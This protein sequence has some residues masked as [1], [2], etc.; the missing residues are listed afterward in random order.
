[1]SKLWLD[2]VRNPIEFLPLR[3]STTTVSYSVRFTP[4]DPRD[5]RSR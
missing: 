3:T 5:L 4:L 1:M 2:D